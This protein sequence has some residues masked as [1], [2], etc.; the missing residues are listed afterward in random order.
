M[1]SCLRTAPGSGG[2]PPW[3]AVRAGS[4]TAPAFSSTPGLGRSSL[5]DRLLGC[6]ITSQIEHVQN[7]TFRPPFRTC[8]S[9][10]LS[11]QET[12]APPSTRCC[13]RPRRRPGL[14]LRPAQPVSC[15]PAVRHARSR[16]AAAAALAHAARAASLQCLPVSPPPPPCCLALLGTAPRAQQVA[17]G[18]YRTFGFG[19]D[20][21]FLVS[22][23]PTLV[24]IWTRFLPGVL[25]V[26]S[27]QL[28]LTPVHPRACAPRPPRARL[29]GARVPSAL[30]EPS[31]RTPGRH[32]LRSGTAAPSSWCERLSL[33]GQPAPPRPAQLHLL[34]RPSWVASA[35]LRGSTGPGQLVPLCSCFLDEL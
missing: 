26:D 20:G 30:T 21:S 28:P 23:S 27:E 16:P 33:T 15:R 4:P 34:R 13:R 3:V 24:L 8:S 22:I 11:S 6:P 2:V 25:A 9:Q 29:G 18:V 35:L 19:L 5:L 32:L 17:P 14:S 10:S 12:V 31:G 1:P 7:W